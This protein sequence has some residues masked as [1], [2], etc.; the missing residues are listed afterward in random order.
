M[1]NFVMF[2]FDPSTLAFNLFFKFDTL[3]KI[4]EK[5]IFY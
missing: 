4:Y 2:L 3:K 1:Y 5:D